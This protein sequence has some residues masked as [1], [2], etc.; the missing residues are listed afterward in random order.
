MWYGGKAHK[1]TRKKQ[2]GKHFIN[3]TKYDNFVWHLKRR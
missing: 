1:H 3:H 2:E